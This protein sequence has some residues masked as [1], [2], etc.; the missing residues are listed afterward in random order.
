MFTNCGQ[1]ISEKE[2][3]GYQ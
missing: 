1:R 2:L 3:W